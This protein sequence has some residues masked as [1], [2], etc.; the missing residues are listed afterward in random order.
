MKPPIVRISLLKV[1]SAIKNCPRGIAPFSRRRLDSQF[2]WI[3]ERRRFAFGA[4]E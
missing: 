3:P 4:D 1:R 2:D